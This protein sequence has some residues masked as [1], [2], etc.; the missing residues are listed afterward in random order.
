MPAI[1]IFILLRRPLAPFFTAFPSFPRIGKCNYLTLSISPRLFVLI[2]HL[3]SLYEAGEGGKPVS[4]KNTKYFLFTRCHGNYGCVVLTEGMNKKYMMKRLGLDDDR[5]ENGDEMVAAFTEQI[6]NF[7][8][9]SREKNQE[10]M[11]TYTGV[12]A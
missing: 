5:G 11:G 8:F 1:F 7:L 9:M 6:N 4:G 10:K 3:F 12:N 2:V